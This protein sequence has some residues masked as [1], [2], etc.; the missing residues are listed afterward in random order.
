M[1]ICNFESLADI[2]HHKTL[3]WLTAFHSVTWS[4]LKSVRLPGFTSHF[5]RGNDR[6]A[7]FHIDDSWPLFT[8]WHCSLR[9]FT[10]PH[11]HP[12]FPLCPTL[13]LQYPRQLTN[14]SCLQTPRSFLSFFYCCCVY[15]AFW[16]EAFGTVHAAS[17][18]PWE[19][20]LDD[21]CSII[22][23]IIWKLLQVTS[24][25]SGALL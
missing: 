22:K 11:L 8:T 21:S 5:N 3:P 15:L 23:T 10:A 13:F 19:T 20:L 16:L 6:R 1:S 18:S 24:L 4:K 12:F 17:V 9:S 14:L 2:N 7:R 25:S